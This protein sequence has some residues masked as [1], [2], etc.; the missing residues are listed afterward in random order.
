MNSTS[1]L[2]AAAALFACI[3][4]AQAQ[5]YV[6]VAG[7]ATHLNADCTGTTSCDNTGTGFK[8]YGGYKFMPS[9]AAELTYLDFGKGKQSATIGPTVISAEL[10]SSAVA[11]GVAAMGELGADVRAA[12]RLGV[13]R[14]SAKL[15]GGTS[16][17]SVSESESS[18]QAYFGLDIGYAFSKAA[19]VTLS[20]DFSNSKF[21]GDSGSV[22]L[23]GVGFRFDF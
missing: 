2:A 20:A 8:V 17:V 3:G 10:K 12:A 4:P 19:V 22:R 21:N 18:T 16:T 6:G 9:L 14:V 23:L 1:K 7:G 13:A 11:L 5:G 15:S